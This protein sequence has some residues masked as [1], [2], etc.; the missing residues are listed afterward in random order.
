M[1]TARGNTV[2]EVYVWLPDSY[3]A[4]NGGPL[5]TVQ[6]QACLDNAVYGINQAIVNST[7]YASLDSEIHKTQEA[8]LA[9][10]YCALLYPEAIEKEYGETREKYSETKGNGLACTRPG[11]IILT[12]PG[13][14]ELDGSLSK[15]N[16][17]S[18]K[19]LQLL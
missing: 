7:S 6:A 19:R 17:I 16:K 13:G 1:A 3:I 14:K 18:G 4:V 9:A 2:T 12:G 5:T 10:H 11:K 8:Q 15:V